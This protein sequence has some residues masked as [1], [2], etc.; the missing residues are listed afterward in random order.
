MTAQ[1]AARPDPAPEI[2]LSVDV[3]IRDERWHGV[4][5]DPRGVLEPAVRAAVAASGIDPGG[6]A[7]I[8]VVLADDA[9]VQDLNR[10]YRGRDRPTNVLS[11]A[12]TDGQETRFPAGAAGEPVMLGD[13]V[14]AFETV[15]REAREEAKA[16]RHHAVH[17]VVH[18]VLHLM[19]YDHGTEADAR[20]M[21]RM[22]QRILA[23]L[24][25]ADPYMERPP[26]A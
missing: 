12:L 16:P 2:R 26:P 17:L 23:D 15:A 4:E 22:E 20:I 1:G 21:E 5:A 6:P 10:E 18:G 9:L 11:F 3:A 14:L 7:E 8:G 19:G 24:G 25:I 13:V